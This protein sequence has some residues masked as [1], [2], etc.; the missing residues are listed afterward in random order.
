MRRSYVLRR[1]IA[2]V[3]LRRPDAYLLRLYGIHPKTIRRYREEFGLV[4]ARAKK[5][6]PAA[7]DLKRM[8][9]RSKKRF[10]GFVSR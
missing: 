10:V 6:P 9:G 5:K 1:H 7:E 3:S 4:K 8:T 2:R